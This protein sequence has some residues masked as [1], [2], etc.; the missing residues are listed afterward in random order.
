M[1]TVRENLVQKSY[2]GQEIKAVSFELFP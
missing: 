1:F 2:S